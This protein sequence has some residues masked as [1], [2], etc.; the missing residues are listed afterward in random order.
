M[1]LAIFENQGFPPSTASVRDV[2]VLLSLSSLLVFPRSLV[3]S[4]SW[5][6][7]HCWCHC[8]GHRAGKHLGCVQCHLCLWHYHCS[9]GSGRV[10]GEPGFLVPP[11][12][13]VLSALWALSL[14]A[15]GLESQ[16]LPW[17]RDWDCGPYCHCCLRL[18]SFVP[19]L[20][21]LLG[22]LCLQVQL[23]WPEGQDCRHHLFCSSSSTFCM[24]S[25]TPTFRCTD[26]DLSS[27]LCLGQRNFCWVMDVLLVIDWK[28][29]TKGASYSAMMLDSYGILIQKINVMLKILSLYLVR[30]KS[31]YQSKLHRV[32]KR[33][34]ILYFDWKE[35]GSVCTCPHYFL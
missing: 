12:T 30:M 2:P 19:P 33:Y 1:P 28:S 31:D 16:T 9:G 34:Y 29:K 11:P 6:H 13:L 27:I 7:W 22:S 18:E 20:L 14:W 23:P 3:P 8:W 26:V 15:G 24:C 32:T 4:C 35:Y 10:E 25:N 21:L 5:C 17:M